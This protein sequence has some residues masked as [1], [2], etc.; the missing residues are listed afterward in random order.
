MPAL[1]KL[2][3]AVWAGSDEV[4]HIASA[5]MTAVG[6]AVSSLRSGAMRSPRLPI[7]EPLETD[8]MSSA[9]PWTAERL[10]E[11][12]R[13]QLQ[14]ERV[15]VVSNR[16]PHHPRVGR[17][18]RRR[19]SPGE[20]AGHGPRAGDAG[21][22]G[23][24]GRARQRI[25][26]SRV[27]GSPRARH[28][29]DGRIVAICC[30]ACGSPRRKSRATTTASRTRRCGRSAIWRMRIR[31]SAAATGCSIRESTSASPTR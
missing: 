19:A 3:S 1:S 2:I 25:G 21:V 18:E 9:G 16:E 13:T 10:R 27:V 22:L 31:S 30:G 26:G 15:V 23:R 17:R 20:R 28:D 7:L 5:S 24:L 29:L 8:Q 11:V 12:L 14:G 6:A 4:V